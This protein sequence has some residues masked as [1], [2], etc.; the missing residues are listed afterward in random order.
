MKKLVAALVITAGL[1]IATAQVPPFKN[2][3]TGAVM[4][5]ANDLDGTLGCLKP[6]EEYLAE[7]MGYCYTLSRTSVDS[8]R[9]LIEAA[10]RTYGDVRWNGAWFRDG[11]GSDAAYG[12]SFYIGDE[13]F[14]IIVMRDASTG[15]GSI[16]GIISEDYL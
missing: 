9:S 12:R 7:G 2:T 4:V 8:H 1:G 11:S 5:L 14:M 15:I 10:M 13:L 3:A 16:A 6:V